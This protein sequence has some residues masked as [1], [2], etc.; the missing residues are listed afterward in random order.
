M[1]DASTTELQGL[2]DHLAA[3]APSARQ[4]LIDRACARLRR[5]AQRIFHDFARLKRLEE[6]DDVLNQAVLRLL[7]RLDR[8][9]TPA[10][11]AEF[12]RLAAREMRCELLDMVRHHFGP[13]GPAAR[14]ANNL[15][16]DR[17][18]APALPETPTTTDEPCRLAIWTEFHR[19]VE[20]LPDEERAVF[21]LV[22]YQGLTQ[23]EA[24]VLLGVAS[25]T[26]KRRWASARLLLGKALLDLVG[27]VPSPRET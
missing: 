8:G 22:W 15:A 12:F 19:H 1:S 7:R 21:D 11:V 6:T 27:E 4:K 13:E 18:G 14:E 16:S 2:I 3:G 9:P 10:S 5:L 23:A 20:E 17:S 24:A 25:I 26:V